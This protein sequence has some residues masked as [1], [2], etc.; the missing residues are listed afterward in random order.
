MEADGSLPAAMSAMVATSEAILAAD[1]SSNLAWRSRGTTHTPSSSPMI[2]SPGLTGH[3]PQEMAPSMVPPNP[4]CGPA[5]TMARAKT[6]NPNSRISATS[7]TAPSMT[8]PPMPR[9]IAVRV[10][11]PPHRAVSP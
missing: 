9:S 3:P 2:R 6:L 8:R 7:R 4:L 1:A 10:M 5:G 11:M